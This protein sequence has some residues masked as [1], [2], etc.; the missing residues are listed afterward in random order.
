M[1]KRFDPMV[2]EAVFPVEKI[3]LYAG[4]CAEVIRGCKL[5]AKPEVPKRGKIKI[6]SND[7]I[8]RLIV[9]IQATDATFSSM[10]TLTY[11]RQFPTAGE[12]VKA[13]II[14]FTKWLRQKI[15]TQYLWFLEFQKRGA[16]HMHIMV[17]PDV[18][19][20]HMRVEAGLRW[21]ERIA[22]SDWFKRAMGFT[23]GTTAGEAAYTRYA[24]EVQKMAAF[25]TH[26]TFWE[27]IRDDGGARRYVTKYA[28]KQYQKEVPEEYRNVG[29]FWGASREVKPTE[30]VTLDV[31]DDEV[32]DF[33]S[34]N[35]HQCSDW[36]ILPKYLFNINTGK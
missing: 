16:P 6:M 7:S 8:S 25:N 18:I 27:T 17:E 10:I 22:L 11:P 24:K 5:Q 34:A 32:R 29:R 31:T 30:V 36:E 21:T 33:L 23:P 19:T 35:G 2:I 9:T 12:T 4:G 15:E 20:P 3:R 13:D 28:A 14:Y 26:Y 1:G